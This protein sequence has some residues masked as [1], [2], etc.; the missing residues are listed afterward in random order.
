MQILIAEKNIK[1]NSPK[2]SDRSFG[3]TLGVALLVVGALP[4]VRFHESPRWFLVVAALLFFIAALIM[5]SVLAPLNHVWFKFGKLLQALTTP[6][7]LIILYFVVLTPIAFFARLSD[8]DSHFRF[9]RKR[10]SYWKK[11]AAT[12]SGMSSFRNQF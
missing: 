4:F 3:A 9:N 6:V 5:P 2:S 10:K 11:S 8:N 1:D 7:I 12:E